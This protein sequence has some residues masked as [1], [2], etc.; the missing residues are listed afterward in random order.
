MVTVARERFGV[1]LFVLRLVDVDGGK[2]MRNGF[3]TYTAE[4]TGALPAT[5]RLEP[6]PGGL[7]LGDERRRAAWAQPG[8]IASVRAWAD[9]VLEARGTP[10][11]GP[12]EQTKA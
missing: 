9:G 12:V 2:F 6:T 5:S 10:R 11:T 8:G 1:D 7:P 4:V 3:V